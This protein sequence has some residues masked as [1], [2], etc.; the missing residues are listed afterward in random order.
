MV[1]D[2]GSSSV[3]SSADGRLM[4]PETSSTPGEAFVSSAMSWVNFQRRL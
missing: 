1:V 2:T 3:F 4:L